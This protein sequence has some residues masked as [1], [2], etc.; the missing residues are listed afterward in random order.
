[1]N[2]KFLIIP[3]TSEMIITANFL[4]QQRLLYEFPRTGYGQYQNNSHLENIRNGYLGELGFLKLMTDR[5]RIKYNNDIV[6]LNKNYDKYLSKKIFNNIKNEQFAYEAIIGQTDNGYDFKKN[7]YLIDIKTYGTRYLEKN[8]NTYNLIGSNK[9]IN[10]L[11]LYIDKR[12]GEKWKNNK[13]IIFIQAFIENNLKNIIYS[14]F[15]IGLPNLDETAKNPAYA[16]LVKYLKPMN[17]LF[18]LLGV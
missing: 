8:N 14:G 17:N 16:C 3:I 9:N 10:E 12:Q 13:K 7:D 5:I 18:E 11:N 6:K 1:M 4:A 2:D 15:H